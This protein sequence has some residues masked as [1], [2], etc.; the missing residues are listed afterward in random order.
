[1]MVRTNEHYASQ[2]PSAVRR[3][4]GKPRTGRIVRERRDGLWVV[5]FDDAV[6]EVVMHPRFFESDKE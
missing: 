1:M 3:N 2:F 4:G 5:R 6:G